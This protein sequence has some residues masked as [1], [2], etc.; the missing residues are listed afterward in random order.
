MSV[1][2]VIDRLSR[3]GT[4]TQLLALIRHLD[5]SRVRP[6]LCLLNGNDDE[7]RSLLPADCPT[8]DLQLPRLLSPRSAVAAARVVRFWK[9]HRTDVVQTYLTD[10]SYFAIP[11]A[12]AAGIRSAVRVRNNLGYFLTPLDR[13]VGRWVG[14]MATVSLSNSEEGVRAL[15]DAE[16][17]HPDRVRCMPNGVDLGRFRPEPRPGDGTVRV[18][19]VANLRPVK[20]IAGLVRAAAVLCPR[21]PHLRFEVAG[22]GSERPALEEQIRA[23]GLANRFMLAGACADVPAFLAGLD[24]AVLCSRSES[25]SN[26]LLEYMAAGRPVVATD[27]GAS[28]RIVRH[29]REGWVIPPGDVTELAAAI[30]RYVRNP[31]LARAHGRAGRSR[32]EAEYGRPAMVRRFE[33]FFESLRAGAARGPRRV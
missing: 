7:T 22:E 17:L 5:R 1:C 8:I 14:K 18:G 9:R 30:E 15:A 11:L 2:F 19:A 25:M 23:A 16:R 32:A 3:A 28:A 26:A 12:R 20:D 10:S 29:G 31:E 13:R 4:E 21:Y 27:V 24:V 6:T 33:D